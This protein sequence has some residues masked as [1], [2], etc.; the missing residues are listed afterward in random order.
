MLVLTRLVMY[1]GSSRVLTILHRSNLPGPVL[2]VSGRVRTIVSRKQ[3]SFA[4]VLLWRMLA[5]EPGLV[6][7]DAV[8]SMIAIFSQDI[9][10]EAL[11]ALVNFVY[12]SE[13]SIN[14]DNVQSLLFAASILQVSESVNSFFMALHIAFNFV[15]FQMDSVC[16]ACQRFMTQLLTTK[17]C[18]LIRQFAEQHNCVDLLN[19]SDDFAVDHFIVSFLFFL[20]FPH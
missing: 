10:F 15:S 11:E 14:S 4:V 20:F 8:P 6:R 3:N 12:T 16:Y 2:Y 1:N 18:L 17:N 13:I 5:R 7:C 9:S 19:S